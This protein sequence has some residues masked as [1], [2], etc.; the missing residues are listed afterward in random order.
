MAS[1]LSG[2][3]SIPTIVVSATADAESDAQEAGSS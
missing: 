2:L 3:L 1:V